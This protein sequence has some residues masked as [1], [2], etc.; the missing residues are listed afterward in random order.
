M[1]KTEPREEPRTEGCSVPC[2]VTIEPGQ[3]PHQTH[4][5]MERTGRFFSKK[6]KHKQY[7]LWI[8]LP[9][10]LC[11]L[12]CCLT[13]IDQ[14]SGNTPEEREEIIKAKGWRRLLKQSVFW[15]WAGLWTHELIAAAGH[16]NK[17]CTRSSQ[18]KSRHGWGHAWRLTSSWGAIDSC[19]LLAEGESASFPS[20][21]KPWEVAHAPVDGSTSIIYMHY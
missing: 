3:S 15:T 10:V 19:S 17:T 5:Q 8:L 14:A 18:Q 11:Q 9:D 16:L 21:S 6:Y 4:P 12:Y 2:R 7:L 20:I 13:C 1:I